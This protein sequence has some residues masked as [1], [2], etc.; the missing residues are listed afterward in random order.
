MVKDIT[1]VLRNTGSNVVKNAISSGSIALG[2]KIDGKTGLLVKNERLS[3]LL[4][5]KISEATGIP[6][7]ISTDELPNY[8]ITA[9]EKNAIEKT[10][11]CG[12][13][14][15]V[16]FVVAEKSKAEKAMEIIPPVMQKA[17]AKK[18]AKAKKPKKIKK[19]KKVKKPAKKAKKK[20][21][22]KKK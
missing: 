7:F 19:T 12:K 1:Q 20:S 21:K 15:I 14:D 10:F 22:K 2:V 5:K 16:V 18:Q 11:D 3:D 17:I 9:A 6:G 8:G 4:Q 13:K